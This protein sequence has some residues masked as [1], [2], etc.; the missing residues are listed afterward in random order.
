MVSLKQVNHKVTILMMIIKVFPFSFTDANSNLFSAEA[1]N[2][3][4]RYCKGTMDVLKRKRVTKDLLYRYLH[5][6]GNAPKSDKIEMIRQCTK[7]WERP[8]LSDL[9]VRKNSRS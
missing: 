4:I 6:N 2:D 9:E 3:I 5:Q 7:L 1:I 8:D